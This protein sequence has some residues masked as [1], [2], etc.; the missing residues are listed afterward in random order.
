MFQPS[1]T[2]TAMQAAGQAHLLMAE[3]QQILA[4]ARIVRNA[5]LDEIARVYALELE[6]CT[7]PKEALS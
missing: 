3:A 7:L 5:Q 1:A 4:E 2:F 6:K